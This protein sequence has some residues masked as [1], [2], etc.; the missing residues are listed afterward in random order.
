MLSTGSGFQLLICGLQK[1][2]NFSG[3]VSRALDSHEAD[4]D[5]PF[6]SILGPIDYPGD[7]GMAPE[8][9]WNRRCSLGYNYSEHPSGVD[10]DEWPELESNGADDEEAADDSG[11]RWRSAERGEAPATLY[12]SSDGGISNAHIQAAFENPTFYRELFF[13]PYV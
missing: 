8:N 5:E 4:V 2:L 9:V 13:I 12:S 3:A 11:N 1:I 10:P 7:P 6:D